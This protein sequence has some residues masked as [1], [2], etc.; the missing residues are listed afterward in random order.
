[1]V[2]RLKAVLGT[3]PQGVKEVGKAREIIVKGMDNVM[4]TVGEAT[5]KL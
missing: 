1:M 4:A 5:S 3:N 2:S